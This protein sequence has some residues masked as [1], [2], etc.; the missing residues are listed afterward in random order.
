M[1]GHDRGIGDKQLLPQNEMT[2]RRLLKVEKSFKKTKVS[3]W[4]PWGECLVES[5]FQSLI[6]CHTSV[7]IGH[8]RLKMQSSGA[9]FIS[10]HG[11]GK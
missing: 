3:S 4:S 1:E 10:K 7:T 2:D 5:L 8:R 6:E 9:V 11:S